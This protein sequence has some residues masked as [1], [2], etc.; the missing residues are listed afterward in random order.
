MSVVVNG[1]VLVILTLQVRNEE[2]CMQEERERKYAPLLIEEDLNAE[3]RGVYL[4]LRSAQSQE[5]GALVMMC[6]LIISFVHCLCLLSK[7]NAMQCKRSFICKAVCVSAVVYVCT[8]V[9]W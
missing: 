7:I 3:K 4:H 9:L 2:M 8:C 1:M 5:G 6:D